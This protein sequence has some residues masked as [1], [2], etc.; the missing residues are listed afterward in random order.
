MLHENFTRQHRI[1][2]RSASF[3]ISFLLIAYMITLVL[4]FLS[5][6]SPTDPIGDPYFSILELLII[7]IS[8]LL[9]IVMIAVN[10]YASSETRMYSLTALVF[11][12]IMATITCSVHFVILTVSRQIESAGFTWAPFFFSFKWPSVVYALD[13][14]AW[15][16]FFALS[17]LFAAPVFKIGRLEKTIR[18]LM[19]ISG[20]LSLAGLIGV[21]LANMN[22]RN[23]G[24]LGY[25]GVSIAVFIL[26]AIIFGR[27]K[28]IE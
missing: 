2:G 14:L 3:A 4:G 19:I 17:M 10:A 22:I 8:P 16:F 1:L 9:V 7:V 18:T 25:A 11:M 23:I 27:A 5:L 28:Q 15:D 6:K 20:V 26:L 13:I 24:I 12:I 21:L